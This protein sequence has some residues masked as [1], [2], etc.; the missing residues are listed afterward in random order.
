MTVTRARLILRLF[1]EAL[2]AE[3]AAPW[4]RLAQI[5]IVWGREAEPPVTE[6]EVRQWLRLSGAQMLGPA[7]GHRAG[8]G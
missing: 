2:A 6:P 8:G 4:P 3:P 5:V 7:T 1:G